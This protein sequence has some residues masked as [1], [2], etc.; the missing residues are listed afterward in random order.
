MKCDSDIEDRAWF[1]FRH[2]TSTTWELDAK[3]E[4]SPS[5][6]NTHALSG[7]RGC[8]GFQPIFHLLMLHQPRLLDHRTA[9]VEDNEIWDAAHVE[10]CG[11]LRVAFSVKFY[12]YSSSRHISS[13]TRNFRCCHPARSA[14]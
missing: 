1:A 9:P 3:L 13:G 10:P 12:D 11:N 8:R 6:Q 5:M 4:A 7:R 2:N 14:P